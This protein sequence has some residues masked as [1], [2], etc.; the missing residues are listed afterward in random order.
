M[1]SVCSCPRLWQNAW[2]DTPLRLHACPHAMQ[3]LELS[4]VDD[5]KEPIC[6]RNVIFAGRK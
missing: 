6:L 1:A 4:N 3:T 5:I 2:D